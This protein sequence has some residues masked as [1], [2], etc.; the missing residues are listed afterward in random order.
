MDRLIQYGQQLA[1]LVHHYVPAGAIPPALPT[2]VV[3]LIFGVGLCV[4]GAKL[5]RWSVTIVLAV[6]GL[7]LGLRLSQ[8][9]DLST[10]LCALFGALLLGGFTF[11]FHRFIVGIFTG[12]FLASVAFSFVSAEYVLPHWQDF[13]RVERP[14][15]GA[16]EDFHPGTGVGNEALSAGWDKLEEYGSRFGSYLIEKE[17]RIKS[18]AAVSVI[19]AGLAGV[20]MGIFFC[21]FTLILFTAAFGTSLIGSGLAALGS[22]YGMDLAQTFRGSPELTAGAL[23]AFFL[24]SVVL[25]TMLTRPEPAPA[26]SKKKS[27]D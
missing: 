6:V 21:R 15:I 25:Q 17:P 13:D 26:A 19:V 5:A 10:P 2:A 27:D 4:L 18:Y 20:A 9:V 24:V 22:Y 1:D 12:V 11:Y 8:Q 3:V 16:V 23:A 7:T 14:V